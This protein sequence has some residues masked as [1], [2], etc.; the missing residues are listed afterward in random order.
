MEEKLWRAIRISIGILIIV[1]LGASI[2]FSII[3]Y[4]SGWHPN[5][6]LRLII[7]YLLIELFLRFTWFGKE[8]EKFIKGKLKKLMKK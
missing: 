1:T 7:I 5:L 6:I 4:I 8:L 2:I 3:S